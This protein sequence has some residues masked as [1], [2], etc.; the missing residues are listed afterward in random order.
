M[1][2]FILTA[3]G[4]LLALNAAQNFAMA[5]SSTQTVVFVRHGEKPEN[6]LGQLSCRGLNRAL[7]LPAII[8]KQ[9]G[10]PV[11]IFAPNPSEEKNDKGGTYAYVRPLATVEPTAISLGLPVD[12]RFGFEDIDKLEE[13]LEAPAYRNATVLVGWEHKQIVKLVREIVKENG[14]DKHSVP[15]WSG[16]DF[17]SIYVLR[18]TR[19]GAK[20]NVQ[21]ERRNQG[22]NNLPETCPL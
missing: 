2:R 3:V 11:A 14:G 20:T 12:T 9:F 16:D 17:D 15:K 19:D 6:G 18:I 21:F 4:S 7:K 5:A 8:A 10:K 13:A 1:R 22:L